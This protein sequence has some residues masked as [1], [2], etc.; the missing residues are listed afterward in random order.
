MIGYRDELTP[1]GGAKIVRC[2]RRRLSR[3]QVGDRIGVVIVEMSDLTHAMEGTGK[4]V[5]VN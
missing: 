1:K 2:V 5:I 3:A 4:T